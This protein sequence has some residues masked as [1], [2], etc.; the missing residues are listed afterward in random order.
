MDGLAQFAHLKE[1][2]EKL[3]RLMSCRSK[4]MKLSTAWYT[5]TMYDH[6]LHGTVQKIVLPDFSILSF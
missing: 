5:V 4:I 1:N 6:V 3:Q 2:F